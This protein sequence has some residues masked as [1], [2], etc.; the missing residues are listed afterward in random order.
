M[1]SLKT[2]VYVSEIRN[3]Q[4]KKIYTG[5]FFVGIL[6]ATAKKSKIQI[7]NPVYEDP[8]P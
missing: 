5:F 1:L 4:Q 2:E 6:K 8:A 3:E 7:P